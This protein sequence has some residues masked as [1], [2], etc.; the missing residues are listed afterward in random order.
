MKLEEVQEDQE[1]VQEKEEGVRG[2]GGR[3]WGYSNFVSHSADLSRPLACSES[4]VE[5]REKRITF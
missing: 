2:G 5:R 3:G 1:E 4:S